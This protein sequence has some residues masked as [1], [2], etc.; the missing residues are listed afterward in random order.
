VSADFLASDYCS[1]VEVK[2]ALARYARG[3]ARVIPI[4]LRPCEWGQSRFKHLQALPKGALPITKWTDRDDAFLDVVRGIR[5][6]AEELIGKSA[7]P[8]PHATTTD[9]R[10]TT[11][12]RY[13]AAAR[14]P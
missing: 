2:T 14:I 11:A 3:E 8:P 12:T 6:V 1:D 5:A 4:I 7:S 9:A 10:A 13:A